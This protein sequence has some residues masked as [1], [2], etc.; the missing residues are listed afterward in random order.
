MA[1]N[2]KP[3]NGNHGVVDFHLLE[4]GLYHVATPQD[5]EVVT[6]EV[7]LRELD[8]FWVDKKS[9]KDANGRW[10]D[11]VVGLRTST[12]GLRIQAEALGVHVVTRIV[13]MNQKYC[14][15]EA[16][17]YR[18]RSDGF[19]EIFRSTKE[20]D[21]TAELAKAALK[22]V[23]RTKDERPAPAT[24]QALARVETEAGALALVSTLPQTAQ[25]EVLQA[26]LEVQAHR[27]GLCETKAANRVMRYYI[28][29][30]GG[31]LKVAPGF[32]QMKVELRHAVLMRRLD[33]AALRAVTDSLFP[34]QPCAPQPAP[35]APRAAEGEP[36]AEVEHGAATDARDAAEDADVLHEEAADEAHAQDDEQA[37]NGTADDETADEPGP[38]EQP[39]RVDPD[40][41]EV[42][43]AGG[44]QGPDKD[45]NIVPCGDCQRPLTPKEIA[46]CQSARGREMFGGGNWCYSCQP[47]H[48]RQGGAAA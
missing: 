11:V 3:T 13:E 27:L 45:E 20:Y 34:P 12:D 47:E 32:K 4:P 10:V 23:P 16:T 7:V 35:S 25:V 19:L 5:I 21:L 30:A 18:L 41:G 28:G 8:H 33:P 40:T 2:A 39:E 6:E 37:D 48:R 15:A 38:Y 14:R 26:R 29:K 9:H 24:S 44:P 46:F 36:A 43:S 1:Q 42:T 17:G 31:I 22:K